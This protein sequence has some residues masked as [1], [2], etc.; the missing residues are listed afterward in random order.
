MNALR[1][2]E[3]TA[4]H[5]SMTLAADELCVTHGA[6]SRHIKS[7][8]E[9]LGVVLL[10]RK[11]RTTEPTPEGIRLAEGLASAFS[12]MQASVDRVRPAPL[13][14]SCSSSIMM[15]WIIPRISRFHDLHPNIELQFNMNYDR[16]DFVRDKI[17]IAIRTNVIAPPDDAIIRELSGEWIGPVCAPQYLEAS[18]L[19]APEDMEKALLLSTRTRPEALIDWQKAAG[20]EGLSLEPKAE[21][22]HFYLLIQAAAC[23]LGV[24]V[25]PRMLVLDQIQS[26]RLVAPFGFRP[27][28]RRLLLWIAPHL[29]GRPDTLAIENWLTREIHS[30]AGEPRDAF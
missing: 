20:Y 29:V 3:A 4:R 17:S 6:V 26:G 23:G 1:A 16:I 15:S 5:R 9:T 27:G 30:S 2:F 11:A 8:E 25:V 10:N 12:L 14:L 28:P 19:G 13:T 7:L 22:D 18:G 21:F 24:A